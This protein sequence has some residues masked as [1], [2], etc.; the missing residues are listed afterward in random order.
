MDKHYVMTNSKNNINEPLPS[1]EKSV[2]FDEV[3]FGN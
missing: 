1:Y 2:L 3:C